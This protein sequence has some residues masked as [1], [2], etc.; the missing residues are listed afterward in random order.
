MTEREILDN[1]KPGTHLAELMLSSQVWPTLYQPPKPVTDAF[2]CVEC[3]GYPEKLTPEETCPECG[4]H[5]I[6]TADATDSPEEE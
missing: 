4:S 1:L 3:G 5:K 2:Y 6:V